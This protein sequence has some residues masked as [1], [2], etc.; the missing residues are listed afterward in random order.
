M[1]TID[2]A[3]DGVKSILINN[4]GGGAVTITESADGKVTGSIN[5]SQP[6]LLQEVTVHQSHDQLRISF[7]QWRFRSPQVYVDLA[8]PAGT[9]LITSTGS[10]DVDVR[11]PLG[12]T[13]I[14]TGSGDVGVSEATSLRCNTGS[15][16]IGV[17]TL[18]GSG[19]D[20]TSGS[21]DVTIDRATA[22]LQAKS[23]SGDVRI[24]EFNGVLRANTASGDIDVPSAAG[25]LELRCASGSISV[26]VAG[27]LPAWLDVN[28]V[29]GDVD[30]SL[31]ASTQP[32]AG[33]PFVSIKASTASGDVSIYRA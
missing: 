16:D 31:E 32:A 13:K 19:S 27:E 6:D 24:R 15:G 21:G 1:S 11:V 18:T 8:V 10:A 33:E 30:I 29:S 3:Y 23:A 12:A 25:A 9:D 14:N 17:G 7:P 2:V 20:L 22:N 26:G 4:V 28:S 5:S